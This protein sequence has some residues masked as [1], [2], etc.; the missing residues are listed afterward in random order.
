MSD[1]SQTIPLPNIECAIAIAGKQEE[2]LKRKG[3]TLGKK[4]SIIVL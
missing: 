2:N 3:L 4:G 1:N